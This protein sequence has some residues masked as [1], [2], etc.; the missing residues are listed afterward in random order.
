MVT[1]SSFRPTS[2]EM[3]APV[4]GYIEHCFPS[5]AEAG[6]NGQDV[7]V[8]RSLL[9][10]SVAKP[11]VDIL[12]MIKRFLEVCKISPGRQYVGDGG[13]LLIGNQD[14]GSSMT[15]SSLSRW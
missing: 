3:T 14:V 2:S 15:A 4:G 6:F 7:M 10:T 12:A 11:H 8:P 1:E 9:T 5:V 13:N